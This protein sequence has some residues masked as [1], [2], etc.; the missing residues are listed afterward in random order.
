MTT[1]DI[2]T[3]Y[4]RLAAPFTAVVGR[5]DRAD[6]HAASPC[7]GWSAWDVLDHVITTQRDFLEKHGAD[8]GDRPA[9][10]PGRAEPGEVWRAHDARVQRLLAHPAVRDHAYDGVFGT[11]TVGRSLV[12]FYGFDLLVH[13]WDIAAAAG[14]EVRFNDAELDVVEQSADGFGEHL[15][16]EGVCRP[17]VP[18]TDGADRQERVLA[19]LGR[20]V[21]VSERVRG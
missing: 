14:L 10:S 3:T 4:A 11:T 16:D 21:P 19:R 17:A 20:R 12:A 1:N 5:L 6:W 9:A 8:L 2:A 18:A 13:R 7:E 15:Y